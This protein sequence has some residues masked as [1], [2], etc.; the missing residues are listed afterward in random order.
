ML[1]IC[2]QGPSVFFMQP[3]KAMILQPPFNRSDGV[4]GTG[5]G[6]DKVEQILSVAAGLGGNGHGDAEI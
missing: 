2:L 4:P 1:G 3:A 6:V 5:A